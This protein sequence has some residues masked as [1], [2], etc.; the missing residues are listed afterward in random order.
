MAVKRLKAST[1]AEVVIALTI[2]AICFAVAS[3]V[4]VQSNRSTV[5]F[6]EVKEQTEFQSFVIGALLSD[7][8]P[9]IR[10]WNG[11]ITSVTDEKTLL[12]SCTK[13][14]LILLSGEKKV[15]EQELFNE[16]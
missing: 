10:E 2:I 14:R 16:K 13:H 12:D 5:Q 11:G 1:I 4:F 9:D 3:Q 8:L 15:W 6:M 7:T